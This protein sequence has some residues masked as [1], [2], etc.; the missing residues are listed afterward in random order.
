MQN[1]PV[2]SP[3]ISSNARNLISSLLRFN[4]K[5]RLGVKSFDDLKN[6]IFFKNIDF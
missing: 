6:H 1:K 4:P 3:K 5:E 2:Y